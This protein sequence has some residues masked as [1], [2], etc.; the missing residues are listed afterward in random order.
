MN[1]IAH[2]KFSERI[3]SSLARC[4]FSDYE[5]IIEGAMLAG[6]HWMNAAL[7]NLGLTLP[8]QDTLHSE[9]LTL[10]ERRRIIIII[11]MLIENLDK[12]EEMRALY[13]RGNEPGGKVAASQALVLLEEI[14]TSAR[15][16]IS[17][18]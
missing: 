11:P 2:A 17:A 12:I 10:G 16:T 5:I 1:P 18:K 9:F 3:H 15:G 13:V 4:K 7:H 6:A 14:R 8:A